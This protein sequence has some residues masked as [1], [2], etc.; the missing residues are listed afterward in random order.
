MFETTTN[1]G[2]TVRL[3]VSFWQAMKVGIGF[4]L[5]AVAVPGIALVIQAVTKIPLASLLSLL[6]RL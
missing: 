5:G 2:A 4:T 6:P 3:T 1:D